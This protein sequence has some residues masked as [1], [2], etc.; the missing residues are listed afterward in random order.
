MFAGYSF[1]DA[2]IVVQGT[3]EKLKKVTN[4]RKQRHFRAT[5]DFVEWKKKS[6]NLEQI[7]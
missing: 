3:M 7:D 1:F 4:T 2:S 6:E 5:I